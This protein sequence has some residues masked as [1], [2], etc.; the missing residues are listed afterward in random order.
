MPNQPNKEV[1][2]V[3]IADVYSIKHESDCLIINNVYTDR[4]LKLFQ[5]QLSRIQISR[6]FKHIKCLFSPLDCAR[7]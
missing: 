1:K 3:A 6:V 5:C 4:S 2:I 7:V